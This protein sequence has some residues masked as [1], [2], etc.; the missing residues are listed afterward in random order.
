MKI[1]SL[2]IGL[3]ANACRPTPSN[4]CYDLCSSLGA[5]PLCRLRV[6]K[7]LKM[8]V[9]LKEVEKNYN[10]IKLPAGE[11][12][13][14]HRIVVCDLLSEMFDS[15]HYVDKSIVFNLILLYFHLFI[16]SFWS[17]L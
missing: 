17:F 1:G 9:H 3:H 12:R 6:P 11:F 7:A 13:I 5:F 4:P 2:P 10:L 16:H 14:T 8:A 15:D